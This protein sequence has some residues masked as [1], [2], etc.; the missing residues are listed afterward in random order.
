MSSFALSVR[1]IRQNLVTALSSTVIAG[2]LGLATLAINTRSLAVAEVGTIAAVQAYALLVSGLLTLSTHLP[3][4]RMGT[5]AIEGGRTDELQALVRYALR[6]DITAGAASSFVTVLLAGW[7][8]DVI[9]ISGSIQEGLAIYAIP[10]LFSGLSSANGL[11]RLVDRFDVMRTVEVAGASLL[12][13]AILAL[14]L[15]GAPLRA[16]LFAYAC[17]FG[18]TFLVRYVSARAVLRRRFGKPPF[19]SGLQPELKRQFRGFAASSSLGSSID[20]LRNNVDV[21]AATSLFGREG[22]G[23]YGVAKQASGT[24][25][26]FSSF[27][28][29]VSFV[30]FSRMT[31]RGEIDE[32]RRLFT[33]LLKICAGIGAA[34]LLAAA[35]FGRPALSYGFGAEYSK[36]YWPFLM[37]V[38]AAA[39]QFV[40]NPVSMHVQITRGGLPAMMCNLVGLVAFGAFLFP[41]AWLFGL[42]GIAA[43]SV[44]YF[45]VSM[46]SGAWLIRPRDGSGK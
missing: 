30:E 8:G 2:V 14:S 46:L 17:V 19:S 5:D 20:T 23:I 34:A 9:G 10:M 40:M 32:R 22:A 26:K 6:L 27:T 7:G 28:S 33:H 12:L 41:L 29:L 31:T 38:G 11:L 16:Y 15:A 13:L 21:I 37:L 35:L 3:L 39:L 1:K 18:L 42:Q 4:M 44:V 36:G 25:R 43:A 45:L 24:V